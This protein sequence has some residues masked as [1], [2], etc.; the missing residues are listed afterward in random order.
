[1]RSLREMRAS[2]S[3]SAGIRKRHGLV[4]IAGLLTATLC[5]GA[6][7]A[8]DAF[9]ED[10]FS[11]YKANVENGKYMFN[12]AGCGACHGSGDETELL[13]GG[14]EMN[15]AIGTFYAPN[16]SNHA[17]GIGGWSNAQFLNA[18]MVGLDRDGDN[19]YPVMPYTSYGGMKPED[20]LDIKAYVETLP[21]SDAASK[22]HEIAF[23]F[24]RQTT[25][26][27]WKRSNFNVPAYQP[28]DETQMERGRYLVENVGGC[29]DCHTPR[30]TTYGLDLE[31]AYQGEKGLTGAV[32][33]DIGKA[34]MAGLAAPRSLPR[35]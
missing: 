15:T 8:R 1:M 30:T 7:S 12:A 4:L 5:P 23:P 11:T 19:L 26:T 24:S 6:A 29:G 9:A 18:V 17:N 32:A 2:V 28:R 35:A 21:P 3:S 34:K 13:S 33:P 31:R 20:V 27:L 25:I 16:I 10:T 14:M 22:E